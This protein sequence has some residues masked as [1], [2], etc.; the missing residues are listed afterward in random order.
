MYN[1]SSNSWASYPTGLGQARGYLAAASLPS[2]L[3]FF[4]GGV[5]VTAGFVINVDFP[6]VFFLAQY[7][8]GAP[9]AFC[10]RIFI[11]RRGLNSTMIWFVDT[12]TTGDGFSARVD[13]Y[14]ASNN[15]WASNP[16]GLGQPRGFLAAA[17]LP[18]GLVFFAGGGSTGLD[19]NTDFLILVC[20]SL[21]G[22]TVS[23][24]CTVCFLVLGFNMLWGLNSTMI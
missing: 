1:A 6:L 15:S 3:V 16:L 7:R 23:L 5:I 4:A 2:G 22:L 24:W 17:S 11:F 9:F 14:N 13:V 21:L 8:S 19:L 18:S 12:C 10:V 20:F